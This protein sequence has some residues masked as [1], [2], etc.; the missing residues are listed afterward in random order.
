LLVEKKDE[1]V[2]HT[3]AARFG[4]ATATPTSAK[5][6]TPTAIT[7]LRLPDERNR[8]LPKSTS[9][10]SISET[11]GRRLLAADE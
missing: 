1:A 10:R 8:D 7:N 9:S 5:A 3:A 4:R 11:N 2:D 6:A